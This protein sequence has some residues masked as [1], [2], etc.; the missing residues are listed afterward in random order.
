METRECKPGALKV[1]E[2]FVSDRQHA[3]S[4]FVGGNNSK[5][6]ALATYL[7][8]R[9]HPMRLD[10]AVEHEVHITYT[11]PPHSDHD[12]RLSIYFDRARHP[13]LTLPITLPYVLD[14]TQRPADVLGAAAGGAAAAYV[15]FTA[16]T[17]EASER[18][19]IRRLSYCHLSGCAA[20]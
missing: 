9:Y 18:H 15:G 19:D 5:G 7:L 12:G 4:V 17:G 3:V 1:V 20:V 2:S 16:S 13:S 10:D 14:G 6:S 8:G 11:P